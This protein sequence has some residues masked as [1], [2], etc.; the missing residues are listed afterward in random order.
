MAAITYVFK[1]DEP[2]RIKA[3][4]KA[5]PQKIGE[6]LADI[7]VTN[8]GELTPKAVVDHAR[9]RNSPLHRHFEWDNEIAAEAYRLDQ[10]RSIIRLVRIQDEETESGTARAFISISDNGGRSYRPIESVRRSADLQLAV[11]R[12][13]RRDLEAYKNRYRELSDICALVGEA[14]D[15]ID[16]KVSEME[17]RV[18][19]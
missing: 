1:D 4:T 6:V 3:A 14:M 10:A 12:Q 15:L 5:N 2:L 9:A 8:G 17:T 11:L 19:A 16:R 18:A 13:A 7:A